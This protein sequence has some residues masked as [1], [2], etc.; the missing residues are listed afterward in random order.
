MAS[1]HI[2]DTADRGDTKSVYEGIRKAVGPTKKSSSP[3]LSETGEILHSWN[4][5]LSKWVQHFSF[6]ILHRILLPM[7]PL[8]AWIVH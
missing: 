5:Q 4:E 7:M 3:L 8:T 1:A 6:C 2:Q